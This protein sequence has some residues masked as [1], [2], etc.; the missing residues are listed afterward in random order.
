MPHPDSTP[1]AS[2]EIDMTLTTDT[3]P[4]A[5]LDI[6]TTGLDTLHDQPWEIAIIRRDTTDGT[7]IDSDPAIFHV[8]HDKTRA[9]HLPPQFRADHARR[10]GK[11]AP[12]IPRLTAAHRVANWLNGTHIVGTNP[13]F[14]TAILTHLLAEHDLT[15]TWH[16]HL[17]DL[18]AATVG[19]LTGRGEHVPIPWRSDDLAETVGAPT[20]IAGVGDIYARHTALGDA[21]WA[22]DWWDAL[23]TR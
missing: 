16:Y 14:D 13:A 20:R 5:F 3:A 15:P 7:H 1:P 6:E 4:L 9:E 22:R 8:E 21:E 11:T 10:Y 17:I 23:N 2:L 12:I 18:E 19:W